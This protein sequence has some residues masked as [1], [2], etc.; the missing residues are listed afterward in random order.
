MSRFIGW[1][2]DAH[3]MLVDETEDPHRLVIA[4][5]KGKVVRVLADIPRQEYATGRLMMRFTAS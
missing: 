3:V 5:M 1:Y 4:D 2:N